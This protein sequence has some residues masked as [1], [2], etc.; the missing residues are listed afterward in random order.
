M[1]FIE[2]Q[3]KG[4]KTYYYLT[5]TVREGYTFKKIRILLADRSLPKQE[6]KR[7]AFN[8]EKELE[9]KQSQEETISF[10]AWP[11]DQKRIKDTYLIWERPCLVY[12]A[13]PATEVLYNLGGYYDNYGYGTTYGF[14]ENGI[15]KYVWNMKTMIRSGIS[16]I[17][18]LLRKSYFDAKIKQ[19]EQAKN[20]LQSYYPQCTTLHHYSDQ[21][22][23]KLFSNFNRA[24]VQWWALS[25]VAENI[26]YAGEYLLRERVSDKQL[27]IITTPTQKSYSTV[28]EEKILQLALMVKEDKELFKMFS[29]TASDITALLK[30]FP[31]FNKQLKNHVQNYHWI[32]NGFSHIEYCDKLFFIQRIK[33]VLKDQKNIQQGLIIIDKRIKKMIIQSK[34]LLSSLHLEL[35]YLKLLHLLDYVSIFQDQRKAITLETH[36]YFNQFILELSR[37]TGINKQLLYFSTPYEYQAILEGTFDTAALVDRQKKCVIINDGQRTFIETS[38]VFDKQ[39]NLFFSQEKNNEIT[40]FEGRRAEGG[41]VFGRVKIVLDPRNLQHFQDDEILVTTMTSPD[42]LPLMRRALAIITD[43]GGI[44]CHAAIVSRELQKPC[45]VGTKIAT[46]VLKDN[47]FVEV[48]ANHG[49]IKIKR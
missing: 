6:L 14:F 13:Y 9:K 42:F 44:T 48:N 31:Q 19:F 41:K 8:K 22:L 38:A 27:S 24:F 17:N 1:V 39:W 46:Q 23:V 20:T 11:L 15:A 49:L 10:K 47:D 35:K 32:Q 36:Y 29:Q 34:E 3:L 4:G 43:E 5:K 26:S 45:V 37:R 21:D 7:L 2:K 33:A 40:E 28:E 18:A 30:K 25:Q 16:V 12:F